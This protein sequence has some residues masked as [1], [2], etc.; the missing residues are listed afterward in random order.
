[1]EPQTD[2]HREARPPDF[3]DERSLGELFGELTRDF[4]TLVSQQ[5]ELAKTELR[6]DVSRASKAG[7]LLGSAAA[8]AHFCLLL[9]SFALAWGLAEVMPEGFAFLI[10]AAVWGIAAT[11]LYVFGRD[12]L[13]YVRPVPEETIDTLKEDMQWAKQQ[14]K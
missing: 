11:L 7:A 2:L 8:A 14:L 5:I 12:Q 6:D 4:G 9:V 1:M 13:R 10:V 3:E